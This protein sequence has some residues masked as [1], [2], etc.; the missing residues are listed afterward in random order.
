MLPVNTAILILLASAA[1]IAL[2]L[3]RQGSL[4]FWFSTAVAGIVGEL[5]TLK[6]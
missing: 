1:L 3:R 5:N 2:F 4:A 6:H